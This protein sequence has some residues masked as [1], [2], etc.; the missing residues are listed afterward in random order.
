MYQESSV[1]VKG[2]VVSQTKLATMVNTHVWEIQHQEPEFAHVI[3][4]ATF[5]SFI[6]EASQDGTFVVTEVERSVA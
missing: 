3:C 6:L 1:P 4:T 5:D 2:A